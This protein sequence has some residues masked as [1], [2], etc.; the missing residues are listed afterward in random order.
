MLCGNLGQWPP[1]ILTALLSQRFRRE[2]EIWST[3]VHDVNI[4]PF[5]GVVDI[6]DET[7]LVSPWFEYGD[8]SRFVTKRLGFLALP[9]D[10]RFSHDHRP[11]YEKFDEC[12]IVR[13]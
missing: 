12:D 5:L 9:I 4:V 10:E 1:P 2:G 7:Y 11:V 8:L 13:Y 3:L 6:A